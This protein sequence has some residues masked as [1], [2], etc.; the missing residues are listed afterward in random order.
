M[1]L[2][3]AIP[4]NLCITSGLGRRANGSLPRESGSLRHPLED[5]SDTP[6]VTAT[7]REAEA[8]PR[9]MGVE[10]VQPGHQNRHR[11]DPEQAE[12]SHP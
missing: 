7:L 3:S 8:L 2:P 12:N 4:L 9:C 5:P 6:P 11:N 10:G 1:T